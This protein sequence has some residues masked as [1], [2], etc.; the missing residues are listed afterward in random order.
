[1]SFVVISSYNQN[2]IQKVLAHVYILKCLP[3]FT[4]AVSGYYD[5]N[6][7]ALRYLSSLDLFLY[8][9]EDRDVALFFYM[10]TSNFT[11]TIC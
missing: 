4:T 8:S 9:A 3:Y 1:M 5:M 10:W 2:P 11:R 7:F 6:T